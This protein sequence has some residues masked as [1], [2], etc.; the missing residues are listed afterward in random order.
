MLEE[1]SLTEIQFHSR[2]MKRNDWW[3]FMLGFSPIINKCDSYQISEVSML[4]SNNKLN[5]S[6]KQCYLVIFAFGEPGFLH[7]CH[8][9][10]FFS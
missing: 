3:M 1:L 8:Y 9:Y 7:Y 2:E 10:L 6:L 5:L 4:E